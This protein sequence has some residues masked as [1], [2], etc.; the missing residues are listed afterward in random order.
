MQNWSMTTTTWREKSKLCQKKEKKFEA[1]FKKLKKK[2]KFIV[3]D[4]KKSKVLINNLKNEN[5]IF[6]LENGQLKLMHKKKREDECLLKKHHKDL[7]NKVVDINEKLERCSV[8]KQ[9]LLISLRKLE[10]KY[11]KLQLTTANMVKKEKKRS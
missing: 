2:N 4:R 8:E 10:L 11:Y 3:E 6:S 9:H 7:K 5:E 1:L